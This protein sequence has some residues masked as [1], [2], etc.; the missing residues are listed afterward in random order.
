MTRKFCVPSPLDMPVLKLQ[1]SFTQTMG[2]LILEVGPASLPYP[3]SPLF[4]VG[5]LGQCAPSHTPQLASA[6]GKGVLQGGRKFRK[7]LV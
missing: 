1:Y 7:L 3:G 4:P 6:R 5:G 2:K